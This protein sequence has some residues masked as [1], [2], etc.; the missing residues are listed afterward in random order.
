[1]G[2]TQSLLVACVVLGVQS[3]FGGSEPRKSELSLSLSFPRNAEGPASFVA[4]SPLVLRVTI[5]NDDR[6][7]WHFMTY[8]VRAAPG[9]FKI[10][11]GDGCWVQALP[12]AYRAWPKVPTECLAPGESFSLDVDLLELFAPELDRDSSATLLEEGNYT[13]SME[14]RVFPVRGQR[15]GP[16]FWQGLL[17]S[18]PLQ[19]TVTAHAPEER[20]DLWRRYDKLVGRQKTRL[21]FLLALTEGDRWGARAL[22]LLSHPDYTIRRVAAEAAGRRR[23]RDANV[24]RRLEERLREE[25]GRGARVAA[26]VALGRMGMARSVPALMEHAKLRRKHSSGLAV[27]ALGEI[28]D[29]R[30]LPVLGEVAESDAQE[31]VRKAALRSIRKIQEKA[32]PATK[33]GQETDGE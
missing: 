6:K 27:R 24:A 29:P 21:A 20:Q 17:V 15:W 19:F 25:T 32:T 10:R 33:R 1:M 3:A 5:R 18:D 14:V 22:H 9:M 12:S 8:T 16:E 11:R 30:A 2:R 26:A 4:G 7:A 31:W 13:V 28:G 23:P